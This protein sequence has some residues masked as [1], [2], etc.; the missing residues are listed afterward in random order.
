MDRFYII[1]NLSRDPKQEH[2]IRLSDYLI[3][4][5]KQCGYCVVDRFTGAIDTQIQALEEIPGDTE[6]AIILGGDGTFI[7]VAG[8]LAK[9]QIPM[10]GV[11]LGHL[12]FLAEIDKEAMYPAIDKLIDNDFYMEERMMIT[13]LP[14]VSGKKG[15]E[16]LSLND[17]TLTRNG[18][19]RV[20]NYD[21]FVNDRLLTTVSGDGVIV[22][23]PTGSTGYSMS[24]GGPIVE[25][26]AMVMLVT[27]I[28][29]HKLNSR[30]IVLSPN[31]VVTIKIASAGR[32]EEK[33]VQASFDGGITLDMDINDGVI[34]KK[35][36]VCTKV[37]KISKE[38]FL[39][40]LARKFS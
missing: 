38:S 25:P 21:I 12:G 39:D 2:A 26:D 31:D 6:C 10:I 5:G 37:I 8:Y 32:E 33:L 36:D 16:L 27:P 9:K 1:S 20:I 4:R 3:K 19:M 24:A 15:E 11:N 17:V 14:I 22:S 40:T 13:G 7:Q 34:I 30:P 35:A 28:S 18:V 23:T 29:D